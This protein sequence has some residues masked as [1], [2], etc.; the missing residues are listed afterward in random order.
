M[1]S[2]GWLPVPDPGLLSKQELDETIAE[3]EARRET[4][5]AERCV[6]LWRIALLH[7]ERRARALDGDVDPAPVAAAV[8]RRAPWL[9][10]GCGRPASRDA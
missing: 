5:E 8:L 2:G 10:G 4:L 3:L 1:S 7:V 9:F 6:V